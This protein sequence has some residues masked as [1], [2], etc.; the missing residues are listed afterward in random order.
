MKRFNKGFTLIELLAVVLII[1][2]LTAIAL[3]QYRRSIQRA[4]S[5]EALVNLRTIFDSAKRY[6][7]ANSE[8][9]TKLN[10]LDV[11]F[12]DATSTTEAN[13]GI[14]KFEYI[15]ANDGISA[16]R[17]SGSNTYND[18]F[19]FKMYYNHGTYGKSALT[20]TP[21]NNVKYEWI[22]PAMGATDASG[23]AVKDS[24]GGYLIK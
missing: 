6:R 21:S 16:C 7:S 18:T 9:P 8:T 13:F 24:A 19:C 5:M 22:C 12:F 3:P 14:G 2:I 4:E 10:G 23:N 17:L 20:C 15:F 11:S 1:G